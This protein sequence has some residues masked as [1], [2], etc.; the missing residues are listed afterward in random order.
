[1]TLVI[2]VATGT[3]LT[4]LADSA[5]YDEHGVIVGL[6]RALTFSGSS[7]PDDRNA[8]VTST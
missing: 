6:G 5:F 1:M 2:N 3:I 8:S 4:R 7:A